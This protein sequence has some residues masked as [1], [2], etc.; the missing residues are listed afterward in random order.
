MAK[1]DEHVK[2]YAYLDIV[3]DYPPVAV[4]SLWC[5]RAGE[6]L[7]LANVPIFAEG[8]ARGDRVATVM[9]DGHLVVAG[10]EASGGHSNVVVT[11]D[12]GW[13]IEIE[14]LMAEVVRLGCDYE[15]AKSWKILAIDVPA[16]VP[17][18]DIDRLL[19]P[20]EADGALEWWISAL[21]HS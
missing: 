4:E 16:D 8:I 21:R 10:V 15:L 12:E 14:E 9:N 19:S 13:P 1:G 20:L 18:A 7:V 5:T 17:I 3:D 11:P 6:G 2:V